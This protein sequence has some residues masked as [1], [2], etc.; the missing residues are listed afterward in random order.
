MPRRLAVL[1]C[2][3]YHRPGWNELFLRLRSQFDFHYLFY[4]KEAYACGVVPPDPCS[5]WSDY[6]SPQEIIGKLRPDRVLFMGLDGAQTIALN[7]LA[8]RM[9]IPT[10]WL[11]HGQLSGLEHLAQLATARKSSGPKAGLAA[12]DKFHLLRFFFRGA[13][14]IHI[15]DLWFLLRWQALR[16]YLG[17]PVSLSLCKSSIRLADTYVVYTIAGAIELLS[18]RD[19]VSLD[20]LVEVGSPVFDP[21]G[22]YARGSKRSPGLYELLIDQPLF[23]VSGSPSELKSREEVKAFYRRLG[24]FCQSRSRHLVVKLHP[25][26]FDNFPDPA[27]PNITFVKDCEDIVELIMES[28]VVYGFYSNLL[29]PALYFR[30]CCLFRVGV[31]F[32]LV[33]DTEQWQLCPV[34]DFDEL[35]EPNL[36]EIQAPP[37]SRAKFLKKYAYRIDGL[38]AE[39]IGAVLADPSIRTFSNG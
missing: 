25:F 8:K 37:G 38:A 36:S 24:D 4:F 17:D 11:Q 26:S 33:T 15:W 6:S 5:F 18:Q 1:L 32:Q 35:P 12:R 31:E 2:W 34:I 28:E 3:G 16:R 30:P 27:H 7:A 22:A 21:F 29:V 13:W 20:R 39:R 14:P 9:G 23:S 10:L 19:G